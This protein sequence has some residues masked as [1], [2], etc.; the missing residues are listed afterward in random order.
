MVIGSTISGK[1]PDVY[2]DL[3]PS[4]SG[5]GQFVKAAESFRAIDYTSQPLTAS[6]YVHSISGIALHFTSFPTGS[7]L[8]YTGS[9]M[10]P[11]LGEG[12]RLRRHSRLDARV[13][14]PAQHYSHAADM[15]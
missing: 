6:I 5:V 15:H 9:P 4:W 11:T 1:S 13:Q 10:N 12:G 3:S 7:S 14:L 2:G 8:A